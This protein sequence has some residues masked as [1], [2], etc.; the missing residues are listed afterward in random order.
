MALRDGLLHVLHG[1]GLTVFDIS[2]PAR[3]RK[4]GH[5]AVPNEQLRTLAI[6]ANGQIL[7]AG[8][9]LHIVSPPSRN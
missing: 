6:G 9:K 4:A 5:Y 3:P 7:V 2:D 8:E 1:G